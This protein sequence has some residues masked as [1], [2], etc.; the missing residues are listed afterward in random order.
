MSLYRSLF[1]K[2]DWRQESGAANRNYVGIA[3]VILLVTA[4][5]LPAAA[6]R[7]PSIPQPVAFDH[8]KHTED[9]GLTCEFCHKYVRV[10][11]HAGL[12]DVETCSVCHSVVQGT[13][14]EAEKVTELIAEGNQLNFK[15]LFRMP[16]HVFYTHRR[17]VGIAELSCETCHGAIAET[18]H[19]PG[20][21]LLNIT[22][23]FCLDCHR[24]QGETLNCNACHR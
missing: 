24:E 21:P 10:G 17:H 6:R 22:M 14:E 20:R 12:P 5:G 18:E 9:L 3:I 23:K 2:L 11:A 7:R 1:G 4:V 8:R 19:P 15:K 16:S 13:S